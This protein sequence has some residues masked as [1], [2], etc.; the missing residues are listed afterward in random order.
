MACCHA[1]NKPDQP[2]YY[3]TQSHQTSLGRH[4]QCLVWNILEKKPKTWT[5]GSSFLTRCGLVHISLFPSQLVLCFFSSSDFSTIISVVIHVH[6]RWEESENQ[7]GRA[8]CRLQPSPGQ[9]VAV[10]LLTASPGLVLNPV[11]TQNPSDLAL[12]LLACVPLDTSETKEK[13]L[14]YFL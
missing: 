7:E 2:T 4:K 5:C 13:L 11:G 6:S 8:A 14:T 9:R 12:C 3:K 10:W 1:G